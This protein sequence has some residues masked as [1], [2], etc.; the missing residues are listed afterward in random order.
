MARQDL[1]GVAIAARR[2]GDLKRFHRLSSGGRVALACHDPDRRDGG[3][4]IAVVN[5][6]R[7]QKLFVLPDDSKRRTLRGKACDGEAMA[8]DAV[9]WDEAH[10]LRNLDGAR[11]KFAKKIDA[12]ASRRLWLSATAGKNPLQLSYLAPLQA[13]ATETRLSEMKDFAAWLAAQDLG[14]A[15]KAFGRWR[16][17]GD[18][19]VEARVHDLFYG[20]PCLLA[21]A[22]AL[23]M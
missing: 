9:V 13:R 19:G 5:S 12:K 20:G 1:D 7:L 21:F 17:S 22:D 6:E 23:R 4:E 18:P 2:S 14:V 11:A 3:K 15:K 16:W 10:R 8:F